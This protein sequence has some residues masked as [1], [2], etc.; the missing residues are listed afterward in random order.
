MNMPTRIICCLLIHSVF[1]V[2]YTFLNNFAADWYISTYGGLT[3]RGVNI[4]L[5]SKF[6]YEFFLVFNAVLALIPVLRVKLILWA[7]WVGLIL[8]WMLP[9]HPLRALL[10]G[11][12]QGTFTLTAILL[13]TEL[14][15]W[16]K[17]N[18][19]GAKASKLASGA[20]HA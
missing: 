13:S 12:G 7:I 4:R 1:C 10:Y 8:L 6:L 20:D 9:D 17:C 16:Y 2:G 15:S 18:F 5:T 14:D 19:A 11:I 3:S